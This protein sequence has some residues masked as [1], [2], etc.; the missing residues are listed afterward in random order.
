MSGAEHAELRHF[1]ALLK[2]HG[3]DTQQWQGW[4]GA[5][6]DCGSGHFAAAYLQL[7]GLYVGKQLVALAAETESPANRATSE[8][9]FAVAPCW[10]GRGLGRQAMHQALALARQ[11]GSRYAQIECHADN[12]A[13]LALCRAHGWQATALGSSLRLEIPLRCWQ[14]WL[15]QWLNRWRRP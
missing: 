2:R 10:Q 15:T 9:A 8:I 11:R 14:R 7:F 6:V 13:C 1:W 12:H 4:S 3:E 5:L